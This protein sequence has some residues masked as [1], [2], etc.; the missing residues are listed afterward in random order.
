[1]TN[2]FAEELT[3]AWL[4]AV[5]EFLALNPSGEKSLVSNLAVV[6]KKIRDQH[7][8]QEAK[9]EQFVKLVYNEIR[10]IQDFYNI[11]MSMASAFMMNINNIDDAI[12]YF[13]RRV[14]LYS[15]KSGIVDTGLLERRAPDMTL[16]TI[17]GQN[18]WL[19][20]LCYA[21]TQER[22]TV[23][24]MAGIKGSKP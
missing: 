19:F 9:N 6:I 20:M 4:G 15:P 24:R 10:N 11:I 18:P 16:A 22:L 2:V 21:S 1:M 13:C 7:L 23:V 3:E 5:D 17:L 12:G 8:L 14:D